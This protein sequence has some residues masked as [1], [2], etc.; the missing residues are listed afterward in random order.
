MRGWHDPEPRVPSP[1]W[2]WGGSREQLQASC[3]WEG[4]LRSQVLVPPARQTGNL[5]LL[6]LSSAFVRLYFDVPPLFLWGGWCHVDYPCL[7]CDYIVDIPF[8]IK[9]QMQ[10]LNNKLLFCLPRW[11][12][13]MDSWHWECLC[14]TSW[15]S[16]CF[17]WCFGSSYLLFRSIPI[18]VHGTSLPP[19]RG[20]SSSS[21]PG[22][23]GACR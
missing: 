6:N 4:T 21:W 7:P 8:V 15:W 10:W 17:S 18:S 11:W 14:G 5:S 16:Q 22:N 3:L 2:L 13:C 19:E 1:L 9:S 23:S 20:S 12:R